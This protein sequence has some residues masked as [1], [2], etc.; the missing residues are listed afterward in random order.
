MLLTRIA[1]A[2]N[3]TAM[4][5]HS[6]KD[7]DVE[8]AVVAH[9]E[10]ILNTRQGSSLS[11]PDFGI[12]EISEV[13]YEFQGGVGIMARA[14]RNTIVTYE[15]RLKNVQVTPVMDDTSLRAMHLQ[16]EITAQ[17]HYSDGRKQPFRLGTTMSSNGNVKLL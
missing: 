17:I 5:R 16:F 1:H 4:E 8:Q 10:M 12:P 11:C 7:D 3:T 6:W 2:A 9:L 13:L 15:P 14:I